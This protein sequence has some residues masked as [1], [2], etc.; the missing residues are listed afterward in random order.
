MI[1]SCS[2]SAIQG[3]QSILLS[4]LSKGCFFP[5]VCDQLG[6]KSQCWLYQLGREGTGN[7]AL[8]AASKVL[9][10]IHDA[11]WLHF[12]QA[13]RCAVPP[14]FLSLLDMFR[15]G[16]WQASIQLCAPKEHLN[17]VPGCWIVVKFNIPRENTM[18]GKERLAT[19]LGKRQTVLL[20]DIA[21]SFHFP[22]P[23]KSWDKLGGFVLA[24]LFPFA[25]LFAC[26]E[27]FLVRMSLPVFHRLFKA[28]INRFLFSHSGNLPL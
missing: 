4:G 26:L 24:N 3:P 28:N 6:Q 17:K 16:W 5:P 2:W 22:S 19:N 7:S 23:L 25:I 14:K 12:K 20:P 10:C 21:L 1:N 11:H 27:A 9:F 8:A 18:W 13:D 15:S